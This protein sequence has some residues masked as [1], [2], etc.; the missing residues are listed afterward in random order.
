M[1]H[2]LLLSLLLAVV[3][4][5][6]AVS[7]GQAWLEG[8]EDSEGPGIRLG[9]SLMLH[10]GLGVEGGYDTNP[11]RRYTPEG[12]GRLRLTP[13][14][15]LTTRGVKRRVQDDGAIERPK[16]KLRFS[17]GLAG[18][19][20]W[21]FA[22]DDAVN[23]QDDWGLVFK[24][25][26]IVLPE[27]LFSLLV[28]AD[29]TRSFQAYETSAD[30]SGYHLINP[31]IGFILRPGGGTLSFELG[32]KLSLMLFEDSLLADNNDRAAHNTRL[33]SSWKVFPKTA[34][35]SKV[36]F[37]PTSYLGSSSENNDSLPL[38][39]LFGL[40]GLVTDRFGVG[41]F[42]GYGAS[43][44]ESGDQF[45]SVI[46][47]AEIM[48]FITPTATIRLGGERDFMDS[49]YANFY[50]KNGGHLS[51]EQLFGGIFMTALRGG[52]YYRQFS[53]FNPGNQALV[54]TTDPSAQFRDDL[55]AEASL[56]FELRATD[57][58][59]FHLSGSYQG[60]PSNFEITYTYPV[61]PAAGGGTES[62]TTRLE[63]HRFEVMAGVRGHY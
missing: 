44:Y 7:Q 32:Y 37:S 6:P 29:Y 48:A 5:L 46:A 52:L 57:W 50:I 58:L 36:F 21:Y 42:V 34:L 31:G 39:T 60:N 53:Q 10:P 59:S 47:N 26:L 13:Y 49:F 61:D 54:T 63:F 35:V 45:D 20:D 30:A 15:D 11:L 1:M 22:Q 62:S 12:S 28:N 17:L 56:L 25:S 38:R 55:W 2:K 23:N 18:F 43:F 27:G 4:L 16:E 3:M 51:Y 8:R 40:Q 19:Y 41:L 9:E 33:I 24:N 14:V